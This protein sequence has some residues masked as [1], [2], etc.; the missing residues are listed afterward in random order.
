MAGLPWFKVWAAETLSDERFQGWSIEERGAWFTLLLIAWRE[1]SIPSDQPSL[2]K[3]LHVDA[4]AMRLLWSA[5]G[6]RFVPHLDV[7]NRLTSPRLEMQREEAQKLAAKRSGAGKRG[8]TSRWAKR[9]RRDGKRM[10]LPCDSMASGWQVDGDQNRSRSEQMKTQKETVAP[11]PAGSEPFVAILPCVGKGPVEYQVTEAEVQELAVAYPGVDVRAEVFRARA[12]LEANPTRRKTHRGVPRFLL[13][14]VA[15]V[16][17][18]GRR[19]GEAPKPTRGM[20]PVGSDWTKTLA[21]VVREEEEAKR[22]KGESDDD[23]T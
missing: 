9:K 18:S 14:W 20:A 7:Q 17:N 8:A 10:R 6:D 22:R 2:A 21:D 16:Q 11:S 1:G 5:I 15:R 13:S 23:A 12:W 3:A 19:N 4:N